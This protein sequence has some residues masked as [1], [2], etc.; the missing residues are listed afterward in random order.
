MPQRRIAGDSPAVAPPAAFTV[1]AGLPR[2][3][4]AGPAGKTAYGR[5]A[6]ARR[7]GKEE[8][9]MIRHMVLPAAICHDGLS[10]LLTVGADAGD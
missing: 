5:T 2:L 10:R 4:C 9:D 6:C 7:E 3:E 1:R 8:P